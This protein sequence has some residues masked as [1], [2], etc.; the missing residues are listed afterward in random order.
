MQGSLRSP[1]LERAIRVAVSASDSQRWEEAGSA[2]SSVMELA[3]AE[4]QLTLAR[5][6]DKLAPAHLAGTLQRIPASA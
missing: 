5:Q 3:I 4:R 6:L 1:A 2:W